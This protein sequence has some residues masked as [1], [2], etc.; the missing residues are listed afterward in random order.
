MY[1]DLDVYQFSTEW[2]PALLMEW[3]SVWSDFKE[4]C[5]QKKHE[6]LSKY[7]GFP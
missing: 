4:S 5:V 2:D 1:L 6:V 7:G 3:I